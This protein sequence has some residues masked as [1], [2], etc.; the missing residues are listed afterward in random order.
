MK[1]PS[2]IR[3]IVPL[4]VLALVALPM[5]V[6]ADHHEHMHEKTKKSEKG[7]MHHRHH[8]GD[9]DCCKDV[10]KTIV[11]H[12]VADYAA[13]RKVFDEHAEMRKQAGVLHIKV[14]QNV[15][16]PKDVTVISTF[17]DAEQAKKFVEGADLKAAMEKAGVQGQPTIWITK[18]DTTCDKGCEHEK[19]GKSCPRRGKDGKTSG[20]KTAEPK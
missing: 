2:L 3:V 6:R 19:E 7:E 4:A 16:D 5:P 9:G 20:A 8:D 1:K 15:D 13:W 11:R 14:L 18:P 10:V 17:K 12:T